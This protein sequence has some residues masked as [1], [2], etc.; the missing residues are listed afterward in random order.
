MP[1]RSHESAPAEQFA[2]QHENRQEQQTGGEGRADHR[3]DQR[4]IR[5]GGH[6]GGSEDARID[7][8]I[9]AVHARC[10]LAIAREIG[11]QKLALCRRLALQR[12][13]FNF[14]IARLRG[15]RLDAVEFAVEFLF[16]QPCRGDFVVEARHK[17]AALDPDLPVEV[18]KL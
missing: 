1:V 12:P 14:L 6:F 17:L 15:L 4:I 7:R 10:R 11:F 3:Q 5:H 2:Q 13:Q 8:H 16:A 9:I 18:G